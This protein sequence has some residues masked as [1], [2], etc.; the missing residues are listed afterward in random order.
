MPDFS[1]NGTNAAKNSTATFHKAGPYTFQVMV[2]NSG[3][4]STTSSVN[5]TVN[6]TLTGIAVSPATA[7]LLPGGSQ[8]FS[9]IDLDQ[10]GAAMP[11]P[12]AVSWTAT[13][14]SITSGG[15]YTAGSG[16]PDTIRA[17]NGSLSGTATAIVDTHAPSVATAAA[18]TP[19]PVTGTTA[20][21][22]VLGADF[23]G[24]SYLTY[25]WAVTSVPPNAA[26]PDFSVNGTN[27]S[28]NTTATF[29]KIGSY[30]FQVTIT[31]GV[32][33]S[34][35]S[36]LTVVVNQSISAITISP[37]SVSLPP[38]GTRQFTA[39]VKDQFGDDFPSPALVWTAVT[40]TID[41]NGFYTAPATITTDTVQVSSGSVVSNIANV[42]TSNTAPTVATPGAADP[43][44][45][46]GTSANLSILGADDWGESNLTYTW[47]VKTRTPGTP[48]PDFSAT[49]APTAPRMRS[50]RF[51]RLE[52]IISA[53]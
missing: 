4:L 13:L 14:G 36:P 5:V 53:P 20:A 45:V 51:I 50:S 3:G 16:S 23:E 35:I 25:T 1:A 33:N 10:F 42:T 40:G 47:S 11:I 22:S 52:T 44:T 6:Q 28:K 7:I 37:T 12:P 17:T 21:L 31:D 38:S 39:S 49:M 2:T 9:A 46:T 26:V 41:A 30:D 34:V 27:G 8:Q 29:H 15:L 43:S 18:A 19:N 24:E 32:G 48:M